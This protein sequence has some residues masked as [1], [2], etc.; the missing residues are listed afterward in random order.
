MNPYLNEL[1]EEMAF[2]IN[3][4]DGFDEEDYD[5]VL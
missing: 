1:M 3:E 2:V 5:D 4:I